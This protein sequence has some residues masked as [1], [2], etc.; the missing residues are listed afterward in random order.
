MMHL[1][2]V[3]PNVG[4]YTINT[5]LPVGRP[6]TTPNTYTPFSFR[7]RWNVRDL[8]WYMYIADGNGQAII[9]SIRV[10][11]GVYLGRRVNHPL[12][13]SGVIM[14]YD[15]SKKGKDATLAD[16]GTRVA[17]I[18]FDVN[19]LVVRTILGTNPNG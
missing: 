10:M 9:S 2:P 16:F 17:L 12:F 14:A 5:S 13:T 15:C 7:F 6:D 4:D 8:S 1:I 3:Q 11:L 18:Y 19:E